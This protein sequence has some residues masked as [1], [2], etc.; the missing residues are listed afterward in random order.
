M[1]ERLA[2]LVLAGVL[3]VLV[4]LAV[5]FAWRHNQEPPSSAPAPTDAKEV[6]GVT[7]R[8]QALFR[9]QNCSL[10]HALGGS[11]NPRYPLD[12]VGA[13]YS[14][15]DLR[16]GIFGTGP[17]AERVAGPVARRKERYRDLPDDD[18]AALIS[19]LSSQR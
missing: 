10:C 7:D 15:E 5:A 17:F 18:L 19:Y 14:D 16:H 3:A 9:E 4:T 12:G 2:M 8:G 1:R 6:A 11:G 13:R